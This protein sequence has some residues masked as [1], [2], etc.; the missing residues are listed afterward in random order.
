MQVNVTLAWPLERLV[1]TQL[2]R[3]SLNG[4]KRKQTLKSLPGILPLDP[5]GAQRAEA[6]QAGEQGPAP[7]RG[8]LD[9]TKILCQL[10]LPDAQK[11]QA[12]QELSNEE[13]S[14]SPGGPSA[15]SRGRS[16]SIYVH[17]EFNN[18]LMCQNP[19]NKEEA[20][21]YSKL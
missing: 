20:G 9:G 14:T 10:P 5:L 16:S 1:R 8:C 17:G 6:K 3:G 7:G 13:I 4:G 15:A 12:E 19:A 11:S 21:L 18:F 2:P